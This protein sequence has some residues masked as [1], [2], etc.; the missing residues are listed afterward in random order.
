M[1]PNPTYKPTKLSLIRRWK[2]L[3]AINTVLKQSSDFV[4]T[5][6]PIAAVTVT[7]HATS[8]AQQ[9]LLKK[10]NIPCDRCGDV[11]CDGFCE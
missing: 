9:D 11:M 8:Q 7:S 6:T 4:I 2:A 10:L 3:W 5:Y 1:D